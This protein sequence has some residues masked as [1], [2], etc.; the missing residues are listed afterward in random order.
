MKTT[1]V[2]YIE[3]AFGLHIGGRS[4]EYIEQE[5]REHALGRKGAETSIK[6]RDR[7]SGIP[8]TKTV[9]LKEVRQE[10]GPP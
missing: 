5:L 4:A 2:E 9:S 8:R 6:G 10:L 3:Q 1:I 7:T